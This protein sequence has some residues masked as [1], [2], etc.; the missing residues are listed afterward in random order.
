MAGAMA[1]SI[2]ALRSTHKKQS[3]PQTH[4]AEQERDANTKHVFHE[5]HFALHFGSGGINLC[6]YA[7]DLRIQTLFGFADVVFNSVRTCSN[8]FFVQAGNF[9]LDLLIR[10]GASDCGPFPQNGELSLALQI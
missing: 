5:C 3:N 2:P 6:A 4:E 1:N 7:I 8:S 9:A 10:D